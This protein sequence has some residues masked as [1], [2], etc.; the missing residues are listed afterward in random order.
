MKVKNNMG[1]LG[2]N[3]YCPS[4]GRRRSINCF[5][6]QPQAV[7]FLKKKKKRNILILWKLALRTRGSR[8]GCVCSALHFLLGSN[9]FTEGMFSS[10][11]EKSMVI[12]HR[13]WSVQY[14]EV[15]LSF[16]ASWVLFI[17]EVSENIFYY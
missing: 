11:P 3:I 10:I 12:T 4:L 1:A 6:L 7:S 15:H 14:Q 9:L 5:S 13:F 8:D 17:L 16:I 2:V